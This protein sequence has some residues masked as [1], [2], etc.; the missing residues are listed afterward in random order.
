MEHIE[1]LSEDC[2]D[3]VLNMARHMPHAQ[4]VMDDASSKG[5]ELS[6]PDEE[7]SLPPSF[8][9]QT[10]KGCNFSYDPLPYVWSYHIHLMWNDLTD[11]SSRALQ[12]E[13]HD[14]MVKEF[15]PDIKKCRFL[16]FL[17]DLWNKNSVTG[18]A[19]HEFAETCSFA[20]L[21]PGGPFFLWE[22][23]YHISPTTF[24]KMMPWLAANRPR[25]PVAI[26]FKKKH[27]NP[28]AILVHP[29]TG[30]QY[31]DLN[32][33]SMWA[34]KSKPLFYDILRGCVWAACEDKVLGCIVFNHLHTPG[35]GNQGYGTC[36]EAPKAMSHTCTYSIEATSNTSTMD[37]KKPTE[38]VV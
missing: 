29:N 38:A 4:L 9:N 17:T 25:T 34:G 11:N 13:F 3:K 16:S 5:L 22:R 21:P 10:W 12:Q 35:A 14:K 24:H 23:G 33:W 36:Y 20:P 26:P 6:G 28:V 27:E 30:C 2:Q 31:N 37:C 8:G 32:H 19:N 18:P 7:V 1:E 15:F